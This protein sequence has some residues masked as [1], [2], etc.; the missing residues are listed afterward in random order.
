MKLS[1]NLLSEHVDLAGLAPEEIARQLTLKTALIEGFVDQR[2]TLAGVLIGKVVECGRH[3]GADRLSLCRVE[4][5]GEQP[6]AV[7]CGAP[8]VATGQTIAYAPVGITL[9]GGQKLKAAKIRGELSEGM[10]CAEDELGLG[11]E[12]DGILALPGTLT[13]G[14]SFAEVAGLADVIF[15]IDNK[16][17]THR[18]DLWGHYGFAR[19]LAAI[20]NRPLRPLAVDEQLRAY[21]PGET[22]ALSAAEPG[23]TPPRVV[24]E[25]AQACAAYA[26]LCLEAEPS[27]SPDWLR[28]RLIACG[29]RPRGLLVDLSNYVMLELGQPTHPFDRDKLGEASIRVRFARAG[30]RLTTLDGVERELSS[31]DLVIAADEHAVALAGL[32]GGAGSEVHESTQRLFLESA[33]FEPTVVRRTSSRL[34]LR[35]D[36]SARFEKG[37]AVD[38]VAWALRRY[39]LLLK[40]LSPTARVSGGFEVSGALSAPA[41]LIRLD[42]RVVSARLGLPLEETEVSAALRSLGFVV[43]VLGPG[44]WEVQVPAWRGSRDVNLAEDLVEEV[45]RLLGYERVPAS[46]P[47]GVLRNGRQ[48][49]LFV[50]EESLRDRLVA[51][52][53]TETLAYS[54]VPDAVLRK[55]RWPENSALPRL[56]N[57]LQQE[58]ARLRPALAPAL[59][60]RLEEWLRHEDDV[61]VFEVGRGYRLEAG[62]ETGVSESREVSLLLGWRQVRDARE[63]VRALLGVTERALLALGFTSLS[64]QPWQP[65]ASVPWLHPQRTARVSQRVPKAGSA[66]VLATLGAIEPGVLRSLDVSG[67]A[68]LL[69][70]DVENLA[71]AA[72]EGV[73]YQQVP[74]FPPTRLDLA[75]VLSY[76][77]SVDSVQSV[78]LQAGQKHLRS[79]EAFDVYRGAPLGA[80]ERSVAFHLVFQASDRTLTLAEVE[81]VRLRIIAAV[82]ERGGRLR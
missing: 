49:P 20:F 82:T 24:R 72:P 66:A 54:T 53:C 50:V 23:G 38:G 4:F 40:S 29:L 31:T 44:Q 62:A 33:S 46:T 78:M 41:R 61:A 43:K 64:V 34:G 58:A 36:A 45:G 42:V 8:N 68:G 7:V 25:A 26:G 65:E 80:D 67:A 11:P 76:E 17:V 12:H 27:R 60:A 15:E 75:F 48:D 47:R 13:A 5:G 9:P 19:E 59:L 77:L 6:A 69:S 22:A 1:L 81:K 79:V 2:K 10:I 74:R 57:S 63:V 73:R 30:E 16:S 21:E 56:S 71:R 32:M 39:A 28:F 18:P 3:P 35:T 51:L 37:L 52:G 55:V 14:A 70:F